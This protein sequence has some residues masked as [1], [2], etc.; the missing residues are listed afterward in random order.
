MR[1]RERERDKKLFKN[2]IS[3]AFTKQD[4]SHI[5]IIL[6]LFIKCVFPRIIR[7][8]EKEMKGNDQMKVW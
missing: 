1:I 4:A 3:E 7:K 6:L 2:V 5:A 8:G